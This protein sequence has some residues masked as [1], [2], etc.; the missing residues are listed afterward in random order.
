MSIKPAIAL[1]A[2]LVLSA[3]GSSHTVKD[4][5]MSGL[6]LQQLQTREYEASNVT[7]FASVLTVLQD[8]G[9]IV[10]SADRETGFITAKSPTDSKLSYNLLWGF[11]KRNQSTMITAF[12]EP[13]GQSYTKVR[14]NFV[15]IDDN[16][17]GYGIRS[18]VDTPIEDA[19]IYQNVFEK[20][21]ETIFIRQA[22][23]SS[24]VAET[25]PAAG[26]AEDTMM[27]EEEEDSGN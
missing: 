4:P 11:G 24:G 20:I 26:E 15:A 27:P 7:V 23:Q 2:C 22:L 12:V 16:S 13:L 14:L 18:R 25:A 8:S 9:Y 17:S 1:S 6:E 3:C 21:D 19:E 10:D 5:V